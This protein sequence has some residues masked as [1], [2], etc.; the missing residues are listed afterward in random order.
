MYKATQKYLTN[1]LNTNDNPVYNTRASDENNVW[2]GAELN[3]RT[4]H[5]KQLLFSLCVNK[6]HK[7]DISLRKAESI[8]HL[9]SMIREFFNS[10]SYKRAKISL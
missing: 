6:W 7:L 2:F 4:E 3:W 8:K 9:K 10:K 1:Y 5:L